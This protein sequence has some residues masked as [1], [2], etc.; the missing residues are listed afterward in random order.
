MTT[1]ILQHTI[2]RG[3]FTMTMGDLGYDEEYIESLVFD[4]G[5][6]PQ[7]LN[8]YAKAGLDLNAVGVLL[9]AGFQAE[10]FQPIVPTESTTWSR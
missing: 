2:T 4:E 1:T 8:S 3:A 5:I 10:S 7:V 6:S 9:D